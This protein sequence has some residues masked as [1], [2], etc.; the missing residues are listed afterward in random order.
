MCVCAWYMQLIL[1]QPGK[2]VADLYGI[3]HLLRLFGMGNNIYLFVNAIIFVI[4]I[5][6]IVVG[7]AR[8][9][10]VVMVVMFVMFVMVVVVVK[11]GGMLVQSGMDDESM[12]ILQ[13]HFHDF[14]G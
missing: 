13:T 11:L 3:E 7:V 12:V 8:V 5:I 10:M 1:A 6:A 2:T 4:V 14:L 9:V